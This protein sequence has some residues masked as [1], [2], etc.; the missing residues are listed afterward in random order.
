MRS[1]VVRPVMSGSSVSNIAL[2][3]SRLRFCRLRIFSST[4]SRA[5]SL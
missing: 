4:V 1:S 3:I 5:I 2:A